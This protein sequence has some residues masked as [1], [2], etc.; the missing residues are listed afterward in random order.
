MTR[1]TSQAL[2]NRARQQTPGGVHSPVRAF[3]HLDGAPVF[4]AGAKGAQFTDVDGNRYTDYCMAFGPLI[5]GH[6]D[7][8]VAASVHA[9]VDDGWSFGAAEPYSLALSELITEQITTVEQVRFVNSGTEAV[10]TALRL[11]RAATGRDKLLKFAGCYHGHTDAMLIEAGSGLG[12]VAGSA[13]IPAAISADTLVSQLDDLE[14]LEKAFA[15]AGDSIA[16]AII[17]PLP[18]NYGLLPQRASFLQRLRELC[19]EHGSLLIF[20][21]VISGFRCGFG[22]CSELSDSGPDIRT[23]GKIIGGG[24]PVGAIGAG[25]AIMEQLAPAGDVYQAGTLSANPLAMRAGLATLTQLTDGHVYARLE[26]LGRQL[27]TRLNAIPGLAVVRQ[28]SIFWLTRSGDADPARDTA[29]FD[30][31]RL[32]DFAGL[33][34]YLL[35]RGIYLAPSPYEVN[36]LSAAHSEQDIDYLAD[37]CA[38]FFAAA[39]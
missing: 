7:P 10:M 20:D 19:T 1:D 11:A 6:Q 24:F 9:A 26:T 29:G 16:A 37:C 22:G 32:P 30:Q 28:D 23:W 14:G 36:F 17:E 33:H 35:E 8:I 3:G 5:L 25:R 13:G 2:Y 4:V 39:R 31:A 18:A 34:G 21:E 38:G 27:E 15:V 12:G